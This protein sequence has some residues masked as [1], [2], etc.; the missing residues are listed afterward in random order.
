MNSY[1]KISVFTS[2]FIP[3][4]LASFLLGNCSSSGAK[5]PST[6]NEETSEDSSRARKRSLPLPT[7]GCCPVDQTYAGI[8]VLEKICF[9]PGKTELVMK[10]TEQK[11]VCV[12]KEN[13]IFEDENGKSYKILGTKG[14]SYCPNR[15]SSINKPFSVYFEA[16]DSN[17]ESFSYIESSSSPHAHNPWEFRNVDL[18]SC[19]QV[20]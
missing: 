9:L 6:P 12:L 7:S 18:S 2:I 5:S 19:S 16:L 14:I 15:T 17:V 10:L 13:N 8:V 1:R 20:E 11:R 4:F 3:L